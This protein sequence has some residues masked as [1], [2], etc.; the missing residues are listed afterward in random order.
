MT[1]TE[2]R[3]EGMRIGGEIVFTDDV[4]DV[5]YPFTNEVIGTVSA[6]TVAHVRQ[7]FEIAAAY[8]PKLSR[9][10][11][12]QILRRAGELIGERQEELVKW[13]VLELGICYQHAI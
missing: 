10:R 9:Y 2:L 6:G 4:I 7:A 3:R 11:R 8:R 5:H 12:S 1:A 13:L